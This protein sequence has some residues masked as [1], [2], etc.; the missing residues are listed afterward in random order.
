MNT[1]LPA[2]FLALAVAFHPSANTLG[3]AA[4][5]LPLNDPAEGAKL[6]SHLRSL[7]PSEAV[8]F[9]G[10]LR[11][12][13]PNAQPRELPITSRIVLGTDDWTTSYTV[14]AGAVNEVLSIRRG[15]NGPNA[16][17]LKRD[18]KVVPLSDAATNQF[19]GSDFALI[20]LGMEFLHWPRQALVTREMRKGRGCDVLESRPARANLYSRVVSWIDQE[21]SGLL[22]AE[23]YD[24]SGRLLKEFEVK[25]FKKVAGQWRVREMEIRNRQAKTATRLQF[26]FDAQ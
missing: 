9:R 6:A 23:A 5:A 8:E 20:D 10:T 17:T 7:T 11:I 24:T 2:T 16:Y 26:Q 12:S 1:L 13:R 21:T 4:P 14:N 22:M 18:G 25:G 19:A 15:R 3:F